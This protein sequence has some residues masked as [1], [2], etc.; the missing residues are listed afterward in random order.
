MRS[1]P[2]VLPSEPSRPPTVIQARAPGDFTK[3]LDFSELL[4]YRELLYFL[5]L[6]E[7]QL[8]YKQTSFGVAW[9]LLQPLLTMAVFYLFLGRLAGLREKTQETPYALLVYAA[10]VLWSFF[11]SS[12][13][14]S[15]ASVVGS[16]NLITKV[17]FPRLLIPL[18]S[19]AS[20]MVDFLVS[21]T[22][23]VIIM[24]CVGYPP[25]PRLLGAPLF[26]VG[27]TMAA[28]GVGAL[29]AALTVS[30]RDFRYVVPFGLQIG[31]FATPIVYP[32]S[33][34]PEEWRL[35][36]ALNPMAGFVQGFQAT[37][38]PLPFPW[39][40][41]GVSFASA[42]ALLALGALYFRKAEG[43]FADII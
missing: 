32:A 31:L 29:L 13:A 39:A 24:W 8:K 20:A 11:S 40:S 21:C 2:A 22:L 25:S 43:H 23:L 12:V 19:V 30:Y 15:A 37:L 38:L 17:Y 18:A 36:L 33:V 1:H 41:I 10:L 28:T 26:L 27:A 7:L 35:V 42:G 16:T 34:V 14:T 5:A 3:L 4:R 6:R 9:T